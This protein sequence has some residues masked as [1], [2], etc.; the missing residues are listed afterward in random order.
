MTTFEFICLLLDE[1][2]FEEKEAHY[3]DSFEGLYTKT[4]EDEDFKLHYQFEVH[5]GCA[6]FAMVHYT[7]DMILRTEFV[8]Y[9]ELDQFTRKDVSYYDEDSEDMG[10]CWYCLNVYTSAGEDKKIWIA[11]R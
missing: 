8:S 9:F 10:A 7:E 11:E 2:G 4:I 6:K 3:G 1:L 5:R